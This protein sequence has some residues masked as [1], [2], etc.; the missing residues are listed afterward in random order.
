[1]P[2]SGNGFDMKRIAGTLKYGWFDGEKKQYII[3]V[4]IVFSIVWGGLCLGL[5]L[6]MIISD[7]KEHGFNMPADIFAIAGCVFGATALPLALGLLI[8][9]NEKC[10]KEILLWLS[11]AVELNAYVRKVDVIHSDLLSTD[12]LYKIRVEFEFNGQSYKLESR[13]KQLGGTKSSRGFHNVWKDYINRKV[14]ILY[15]PKFN[16]VIILK[17]H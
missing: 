14:N 16:E 15:S 7:I 2:K 4:F 5:I 6:T 11:D 12:D 8:S 3:P 10:R 13:G 9:R 17:D 1:M